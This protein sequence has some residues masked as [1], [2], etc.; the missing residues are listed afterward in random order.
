[1]DSTVVFH[2][3]W[4]RLFTATW[5]H[6]D[7]GHLASN[8]ALGLVLFGLTMGL[9][10]TGVGLLAA[11]LAGVGGNVVAGIFSSQPHYSL[12][13]SGVVMGTVGLLAAQSLALRKRSPLALKYVLSSV[14]GGVMM[15][16]LLGVGPG[17]DIA[18]HFGGFV[19]GFGIGAV[20][21]FVPDA[22]HK[23]VL[24]LLAG[25]AFAVLTIVPWWLALVRG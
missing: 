4:W 12:G 6:A 8:A 19:C 7:A 22:A 16:L 20:L 25:L 3:Q 17:T 1:M 24:N 23:P 15:F 9:Y 5:L 2:K 10:G 21:A 18:A 11:Y 13:A 14:A